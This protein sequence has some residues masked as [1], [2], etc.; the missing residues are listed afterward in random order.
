MSEQAPGEGQ[1]PGTLT[2]LIEEIA[3]G[4]PAETSSWADDLR[5]GTRIGR[6]E[7]LRETGRGGF[8]V[9]FEARDRDLGRTVA[10]KAL[11]SRGGAVPERRLLAEA[12]VAARLSHP[13]VVTVLDVGRAEGGAFLVQEFVAGRPLWE[14][15]AGGRLDTREAL[16]IGIEVARGLAHAHAH[17]VVHRDLTPANVLVT[18]DGQVKILDL[19]MAAAFGRRKVEGGT[20]E[21]MAPEQA[22]SD[23]E[24][25]RTDVYALGVMLFRMLTGVSPVRAREADRAPAKGLSIPEAPALAALIEAMLAR[26]PGARPRD[27]GE[28]LAALQH[29][30]AGLPR[31]P[32]GRPIRLRPPPRT[33]WMLAGAAVGGGVALLLGAAVFRAAGPPA[34]DPATPM[35]VAASSS[36]TPCRWEW[37]AGPGLGAL[38]EG[39]VARNGAFGGQGGARVEGRAAWQQRSDWNQLF[40]PVAGPAGLDPFAVEVELLLPDAGEIRAAQFMAFTDPAGPDASDTAHGV[41][42][43]LTQDPTRGALFDWGAFGGNLS[44]VVY[45]GALPAPV[46]GRW[47]KLRLEGSKARGWL[48]ALVDGVPV[49]V[50]VGPADLGGRHVLL[51][52]GAP[53]YQPSGASWRGLVLFRGAPDCQ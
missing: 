6:Y 53:P 36:T 31:L 50:A 20:A 39:A 40:V 10:F 22:R 8:G 47:R 32:P 41:G 7:L 11:R 28:V 44:K 1:G 45:K 26:D 4:H 24:D 33:R 3:R 49:L 34:A 15:M 2:A 5:P 23:P 38:P 27:G 51:A 16:R 21:Y 43:G 29:A 12:E 30:E 14:L 46:A 13:N 18:E 35:V 25:E 37:V 9:V 52:S 17:G 19:G 48:R 42:L